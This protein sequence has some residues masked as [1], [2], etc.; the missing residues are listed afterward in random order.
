LR[1]YRFSVGCSE[2]QR[3]GPFFKKEV[4]VMLIAERIREQL[5]EAKYAK[6][7]E[8]VEGH[9]EPEKAPFGGSA[10]AGSETDP[11]EANRMEVQKGVNGR[12]GEFF[13]DFGLA[14]PNDAADEA[15]RRELYAVLASIFA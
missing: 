10:R 6:V 11:V 3:K 9:Y 13:E 1:N 15:E 14:L 7:I 12:L 2:I 5:K 4:N 8:C